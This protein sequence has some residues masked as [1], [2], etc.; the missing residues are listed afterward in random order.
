MQVTIL[1]SGSGKS[2]LNRRH[3]AVLVQHCA[4]T[5]LL[6]C[7]EGTSQ[8]LL[9]HATAPDEISA[10]VISHLHPDHITGLYMLVQNLYLQGRKRPLYIYLPERV[11]DVVKSFELFYLFAKRLPY[12]LHFKR[13]TTISDDYPCITITPTSHLDGYRTFIAREGLKNFCRSWAIG[14]QENKQLLYSADISSLAEIKKYLP[15]TDLLIIDAFHTSVADIMLLKN[16]GIGK[17]VLNHGL[18]DDLKKKFTRIM[19][20]RYEIAKDDTTY[21]L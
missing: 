9:K 3:A 12:A 4:G 6:D 14:I 10:I 18:S 7:G 21:I 5:F 16:L 8:A 15:E 13:I 11:E 1:G 19:D 2:E 17:I 20:T